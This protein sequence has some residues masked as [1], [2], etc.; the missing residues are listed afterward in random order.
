MLSVPK[1]YCVF[2]S[3]IFISCKKEAITNT[4]MIGQPSFPPSTTAQTSH[5]AL[6]VFAGQ[7]IFIVF[8]TASCLLEGMAETPPNVR[9]AWKQIS[10][11]GD[12]VIENP[13]AL[14]TKVLKLE[15]G[16]YSF[17]LAVTDTGGLTGKDTVSVHVLE[18]GSGTNEIIF[19]D[20]QWVCPMGCHIRIEKIYTFI[21]I[22]VSF[23][24]YMKRDG[25]SQWVEIINQ[26]QGSGKYVWTI[27]NNGLEILEDQTEDPEDSPDVKIIF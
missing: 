7:D 17:E 2:A 25:S 4:A 9:I 6:S 14:K 21:P 20:L 12:V 26:S 24:A 19:R 1:L 15:K 10:G 18:K 22:G 16:M 5:R 11:P 27:Y 13:G 3:L 8:P 23:T